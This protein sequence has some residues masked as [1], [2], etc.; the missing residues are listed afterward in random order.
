MPKFVFPPPTV[1][2]LPPELAFGDPDEVRMYARS[3]YGF[4]L[5]VWAPLR[6]GEELVARLNAFCAGFP[7]LVSDPRPN[8]VPK[9]ANEAC[10]ALAEQAKR[11]ESNLSRIELFVLMKHNL[12]SS[13]AIQELIQLR[14]ELE[15]GLHTEA[16]YREKKSAILEGLVAYNREKFRPT[17]F[18]MAYTQSVKHNVVVVDNLMGAAPGSR[19]SI[20]PIVV[21][22]RSLEA[23]L[24]EK[25]KSVDA[26]AAVA[27]SPAMASPLSPL[28]SDVSI[29]DLMELTVAPRQA[30]RRKEERATTGAVPGGTTVIAHEH[31]AATPKDWSR[32]DVLSVPFTSTPP[33]QTTTTGLHNEPGAR[34]SAVVFSSTQ[35]AKLEELAKLLPPVTTSSKSADV[36]APAVAG[37]SPPS[38]GSMI[39]VPTGALDDRRVSKRLTSPRVSRIEPSA[40]G[41]LATTTAATSSSSSS[42]S[43]DAAPPPPLPEREVHFKSFEIPKQGAVTLQ[44]DLLS[45]VTCGQSLLW[46]P[47]TVTTQAPKV[48]VE[49]IEATLRDPQLLKVMSIPNLVPAKQF[50]DFPLKKMSIGRARVS[51]ALPYL[52]PVA[53]RRSRYTLSL[54]LFGKG[55]KKESMVLNIALNVVDPLQMWQHRANQVFGTPFEVLVEREKVPVPRIIEE[56]RE[57]FLA[58]SEAERDSDSG[59]IMQLGGDE[60][61]LVSWLRAC[62]DSGEQKVLSKSECGMTPSGAASLFRLFLWSAPDSVIPWQFWPAL[63]DASLL[64]QD[65]APRAVSNELKKI[66]VNRWLILVK[67]VDVLERWLHVKSMAHLP[68]TFGP[69]IVR[70]QGRSPDSMAPQESQQSA[71]IL[72][73]ILKNRLAV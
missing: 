39:R 40:A 13:H 43:Q 50:A 69:T 23:L 45:S 4:L 8:Q 70:P 3:L 21:H 33:P 64:S 37:V 36:V 54:T 73:L 24:A 9:D 17:P 38:A 19:Y 2:V 1:T 32:Q 41:A 29:D 57:Y 47:I 28:K 31:A 34:H 66:P 63:R 65:E 6:Y 20:N 27:A 15:S 16:V 22:E 46:L 53:D 48:V 52:V 56:Y 51:I 58:L 26:A 7:D 59:S 61:T 44:V 5:K 67:V 72:L 35:T 49:G 14:A 71:Q 55:I 60:Q 42:A 68:E 10:A 30:R 18:Y 12:P 62:Y 11:M 25:F